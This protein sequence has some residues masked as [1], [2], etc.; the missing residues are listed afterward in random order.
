MTERMEVAKAIIQNENGEFLVAKEEETG[1]WELPGGIIEDEEDRFESAKR[2]VR[3]ETGL[4]ISGFED[5]VRLELADDRLIDCYMVYA[6]EYQG[7]LEVGGDIAEA[8]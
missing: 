7:D 5:I 3:E 2:E 4:E 6:E 1:K 8:R